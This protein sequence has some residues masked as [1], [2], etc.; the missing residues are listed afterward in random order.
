MDVTGVVVPPNS[1]HHIDHVRRL[2][3]RLGRTLLNSGI[4][5]PNVE[6]ML[7][8]LARRLDCRA[9]IM[10]TPTSMMFTLAQGEETR[11]RIVRVNPGDTDFSRLSD[12]FQLVKDVEQGR[13][14]PLDAEHAMEALEVEP[15]EQ[16]WGQALHLTSSAI[17]L[18]LISKGCE[19][20][21][22]EAV[23]DRIFGSALSCHG[24]GKCPGRY[25]L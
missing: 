12:V 15:A 3:T 13:M 21:Y 14:S 25:L 18:L 22:G 16:Q 24:T 6:T 17:D 9:D 11:T 1:P 19:V 2:I 23:A 10:S 8:T 4:P 5:C 20:G 7:E